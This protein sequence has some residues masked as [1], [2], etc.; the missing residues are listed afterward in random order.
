[1]HEHREWNLFTE[2]EWATVGRRL[3]LSRR[4]LDV[5]RHVFVERSEA[6]IA[7]ALGIS[8][9]TVHTYLHRIFKKL[10]VHSRVGLV[11]AI[12]EDALRRGGARDPSSIKTA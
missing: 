2:D 9:H 5:I 6:Q 1:M 3:G 10:R 11:L 4:E 7:G 8:V 12:L